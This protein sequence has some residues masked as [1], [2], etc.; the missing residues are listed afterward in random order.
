[1]VNMNIYMTDIPLWYDPPVGP[2]VRIQISHNSLAEAVPESP[3]GDRWT[4]NYRSYLQEDAND[5]VT[6]FMPDGRQDIFTSDGLGGYTKEAGVFST[7]TK[8]GDNDFSL[9]LLNDTVYHYNKASTLNT[10]RTFLSKIQDPYNQSLT[11]GYNN[12]LLETITDALNRVTTLI[13]D[14]PADGLIDRI[15]DPYGRS[16]YFEYTNG[17]LTKITDMGEYWTEFTYDANNYIDTL[18]NDSGTWRFD[19]DPSDGTVNID[20]PYPYPGEPMGENYRITITDPLRNKEE[21][22]SFGT[23][24]WYISPN[25]YV[26][27]ISPDSNNYKSAAKTLYILTESHETGKVSKIQ[28]PGGGY[29]EYRDY[30]P[31]TQNPKTIKDDHGHTTR[32]TYNTNGRIKSLTDAKGNITTINYYADNIDVNEIIVDLINTPGND[33]IILKSFT[34]NGSTH[35]IATITERPGTAVSTTT[36]FTYLPNGQLDTITNAQGSSIEMVTSLVYDAATHDLAEIRKNG[37]TVASF[38]YD[39]IGRVKTHTD[40]KDLTITYWEYSKLN[41]PTKITFPDTVFIAGVPESKFVNINYSTCCPRLLDS[42]T[43]RAGL[44]TSYTY[45]AIRRL[46]KVQS[47]EGII[48]YDYDANGNLKILTDADGK[49]IKFDYDPDNRLIEKTYGNDESINYDYD[50]AG[51]L[52]KIINLKQYF[53]QTRHLI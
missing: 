27:Y 15:D 38:T 46:K 37:N 1:M 47:P 19:I 3:F 34:Y 52:T 10:D 9:K 4:F 23:F 36:G 17:S 2:S 11:F 48:R 25:D 44:T 35:N 33:D 30:D 53:I 8:T 51:L 42:R 45:D 12:D 22:Y 31:I 29:I 41:M 32:Y 7:L 6:V 39:N 43:D 21:Y 24:S 14:A 20:N 49:A 16:A 18:K 40:D 26:P 50:P 5:N 13:D 28:S